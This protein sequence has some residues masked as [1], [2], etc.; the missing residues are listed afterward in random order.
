M[1][2]PVQAGQAGR[3]GP[4][5]SGADDLHPNGTDTIVLI[6]GLWV[7]ALIWEQWI[8]RYRARGY[9]VLA[10]GWP[11]LDGGI[12]ELR[13]DPSGIARLRVTDIAAHY[14]HLIGGLSPPPALI[15]HCLGG[16][17]VQILLDGGLGAAGVAIN[18]APPAARM[19]PPLMTSAGFPVLRS[20]ARRRSAVTLTARQFRRALAGAL[21]DQQAE[22]AYA[23]YTIPAP[24]GLVRQAAFPG[25]TRV[26]FGNQSR[27]PL[28]LIGGGKD[29]IFPASLTRASYRRYAQSAAITFYREYPGRSHYT[30]GEPGW[31]HVADYTLRWAMDNARQD[32]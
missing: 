4:L 17:V 26:R 28:L 27:A 13:R 22:T 21:D 18:P 25:R 10:P 7:T 24:G 9:R 5:T 31:E 32:L 2:M 3:R 30:I 6:H 15:G 16:L 12:A 29:R 1:S 14:G 19:L 8:A 11:G 20:S 23:R